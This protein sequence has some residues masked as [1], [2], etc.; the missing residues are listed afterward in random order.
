VAYR[1]DTHMLGTKCSTCYMQ[2]NCSSLPNSK[3]WEWE[4]QDEHPPTSANRAMDQDAPADDEHLETHHYVAEKLPLVP[5]TCVIYTSQD[6]MVVGGRLWLDGVY[7]RRR[8]NHLARPGAFFTLVRVTGAGELWMTDVTIQGDKRALTQAL[9]VNSKAF[10]TRAH[11]A[12][13]TT[14]HTM[15]ARPRRDGGGGVQG[16]ASQTIAAAN[17]YHRST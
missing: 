6:L 9:R 1:G 2:G 11:P 16:C 5:R 12:P 13:G 14:G 4:T 10:G 17:W 15:H 7:I 8:S 3:G